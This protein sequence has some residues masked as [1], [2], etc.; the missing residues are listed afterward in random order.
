MGTRERLLALVVGAVAIAVGM[1]WTS[2]ASADQIITNPAQVAAD[3]SNL[4][5]AYNSSLPGTLVEARYG[6]FTVPANSQVHNAVDFSAPA[7]CT[8][9]Y[10]TDIMPNLVYDGDS[11]FPPQ[12]NPPVPQT[13]NLVNNMMMHHFVLI[14]SANQDPV[15]P[16]GL[17]GQIG[18]RFFASG[19]ERSEMHLA[20]PYG[21]NNTSSTWT[22]IY[23]LVNKG[24]ADKHISIQAFFR[25][26]TDSAAMAAKP[27][28][29]DINGC[30]DSNYT[31]P[32]G[33]SETNVSWTSTVAGRI[34]GI[35]GHLHDVDITDSNPCTIHC[36]SEGGGIAESLEL[37]GGA[38]NYW[39]PIPPD[40]P[41]PADIT[42]T[43]VCRSEGYYGTPTGGTQ[44]NG[45]LDTMS[46]CG[47][48]TDLPAGHQPE[49]YPAGGAYPTGGIP[50]KVGDVL[51]VHSEYQ[52]GT[53]SPVTDAMGIM[54]P[55]YVPPG[56]GFARPKGASPMRISLV[57][58]YNQC[59]SGNST[60][61]A[62]LSY[63]SCAP[64]AASSS[65]LTMGTPDSN[66][67]PANGMG[68]VTL[69]TVPGPPADLRLVTNIT[70]VRNKSDLS[71]YTGQLNVKLPLR[72]TDRNNGP[73]EVGTTQDSTYTFAVPCTTT[74]STTV[75]STCS[76]DTT[77]NALTPNAI[78][79]GTRQNFELGKVDVY[80]GG[81]TRYLTEGY[82][83]P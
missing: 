5:G 83:V 33:Y 32:T 77:A 79:A 53:G 57:P 19:N 13:A 4:R 2:A 78:V 81:N 23:H 55:W 47:I 64:P 3:Y 44:W 15:C 52:N 24:P 60:H 67:Q 65:S 61:G 56:P 41:P 59:T 49:A 34:I 22:L 71:D 66:A 82:F 54:V 76:V 25:Y 50:F 51:R 74:V 8:N 80:D 29:L 31:V 10:I 30:G 17:Q 20:K 35:A 48:E 43:T 18:E 45:H 6:P 1:F 26:R 63:P 27:L 62:P 72:I 75:G 38:S 37:V 42:G 28:W 46:Q 73:S 69:I 7:P 40:N 21:Y 11:N 39:G 68:S 70:D 12:G 9:C 14:N 16:S 36:A 58:A